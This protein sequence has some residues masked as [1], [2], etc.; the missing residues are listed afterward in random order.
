MAVEPVFLDT[1]ALFAAV[2]SETGGARQLLKLGE[3]EVITLWVGPT[4][5]A[6]IDAVLERKSPASKARLALLLD[7]A[8]VQVGPEADAATLARAQAVVPYPPDAV[9]VAEALMAE[10]TYLVSLDRQHLVGNPRATTL[11]LILGTPGDCL[12]WLRAR[13]QIE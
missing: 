2:L 11:P 12:A 5:L 10:V 3:A 4:V 13:L 8:G 1:S 6:E 9:I 7:S